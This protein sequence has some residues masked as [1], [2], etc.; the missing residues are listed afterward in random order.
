VNVERLILVAAYQS[1]LRLG[2]HT[3]LYGLEIIR[4]T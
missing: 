3:F 1:S 4:D 2:L